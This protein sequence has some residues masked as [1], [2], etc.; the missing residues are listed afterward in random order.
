MWKVVIFILLL[1][2]IS[3]A[4]NFVNS[5]ELQKTCGLPEIRDFNVNQYLENLRK[6]DPL[7][8]QNLLEQMKSV[9]E[10]NKINQ[11]T[12][13]FYAYNFRTSKFETVDATL[14][15]TGNLT[16]I[17]VENTSW[18]KGYVNDDI[19][20]T[21]LNNL[22]NITGSNSIDPSKGI[23]EVDTTLFGQP[24]DIDH[25]GL[26]D[27]LIL[28]I[29]DN[30]DSTQS[31]SAYYAGF[32]FPND[33]NLSSG[34]SN[35][36]DLLYLDSHPGIYFDGTRRTDKVLSTTAHEFQHLI[37][38]NY[39]KNEDDWVNEG[40]S[41]LAGTY[42][43]YGIDFPY[44]FLDNTNQS[45]I[46]WNSE[47]KDYSR[48]NLWTLYIAEQ[49]GRPFIKR[50][51]QT[52][53][54]GIDGFNLAMQRSG[55]TGSLSTVFP[56][57]VLALWIN[58]VSYNPQ[59]GYQ[60][61][62]ARG[63]RA[64]IDRLNYQY[65]VLGA[66][67]TVQNYAAVY[68]R[69]RGQD[70]LRVSFF[71]GYPS[72]SWVVNRGGTYRILSPVGGDISFPNF[73][74]DSTYVMIL[75]SAGTSS[76]YSY[77]ASANFSL[78]RFVL[79]Y[80]D[81]AVNS[82]ISFSSPPAIAANKFQVPEANLKLESISFFNGSADYT[83]GIHVYGSAGGSL[84]GSDLVTPIDTLLATGNTWVDLT[85]PQPIQGLITGENFFVGVSINENDKALG[86]DD[87]R[88]GT[89]ISYVKLGG[90]W[91][92]LSSTSQFPGIWM[93]RAE[94]TGLVSSDS[95]DLPG[96]G[97]FALNGNDPNPFFLKSGFTNI[98]FAIPD[99]GEIRMIVY[100]TL[101]QKV[102]DFR[103]FVGTGEP[104]QWNGR[105]FEGPLA[106][107]MYFYQLIYRNNRTGAIQNSNFKKMI[108]F[109]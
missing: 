9:K 4:D 24:P 36:M 61:D 101:G 63:L 35:K 44:L 29:Q 3:V 67:G 72:H 93:I 97:G 26:V 39:D 42:C 27:F 98:R 5:T 21:I 77:D 1:V 28:D 56:D 52:P 17:W 92:P 22:E 74:D 85:F 79:S 7:A 20:N 75:E 68:H 23:I 47:V 55:L 96:N 100:N 84:P 88:S 30:F 25:N 81:N 62:Q 82:I 40:L 13:M 31:G 71:G 46:T 41:E 65:P 69:F 91:Y 43:G 48:V 104:I 86:Y 34:L 83:A 49:L 8:Y 37:H 70:S 64:R 6:T 38:Y 18:T 87:S 78:R 15:R 76:S 58:N 54:H 95:L 94:M 14:R 32:F 106:S 50:L 53:E 19:L 57:W 107:G 66:G 33:Q 105:G 109:R 51:T 73:N 80:D 45:L 99:P 90:T 16:E 102:A 108:V 10:F 11:T 12:K 2:G 59:Y 89:G 103:K 60:W